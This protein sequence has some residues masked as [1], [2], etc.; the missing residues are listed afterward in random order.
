MDFF[1]R[2]PAP[3]QTPANH[4]GQVY[5]VAALGAADIEATWR[6]RLASPGVMP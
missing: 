3:R 6:C 2:R 4:A 1:K 5:L